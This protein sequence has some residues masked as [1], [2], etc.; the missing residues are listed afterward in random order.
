MCYI[1]ANKIPFSAVLAARHAPPVLWMSGLLGAFFVT[2]TILIAPRL[3][4]ALT[5]G[6]VIA[7]QMLVSLIFDQFGLLGMPVKELSVMRLI[8]AA[9]LV[10]GVILIRKY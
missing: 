3:G 6:L 7:G 4:I 2:T 1:L 8:G 9:L 10:A 5:F